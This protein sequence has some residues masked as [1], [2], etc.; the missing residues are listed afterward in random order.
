MEKLIQQSIQ[1]HIFRTN[2]RNVADLGKVERLFARH[3]EISRW[4]IDLH[5]WEKVLKV[6]TQALELLEVAG[7]VQQIGFECSEL[8]H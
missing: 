7:L 1:T 2:I 4:T 6:E 8:D 3:S 5:D